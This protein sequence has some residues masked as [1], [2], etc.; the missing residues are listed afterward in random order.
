MKRAEWLHPSSLVTLPVASPPQRLQ[1][2]S[3]R[4]GIGG[5]RHQIDRYVTVAGQCFTP[6]L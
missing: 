3:F 5:Y 1:G 2:R 4:D 6:L